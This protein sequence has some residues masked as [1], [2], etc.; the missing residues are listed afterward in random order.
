MRETWRWFGSADQVALDD[1]AQAGA[2]GIVTALHHIAPGD[3]WSPEEI[4]G[5]QAEIR[6]RTAHLPQPMEWDVVE[7]LPVSEDIKRQTGNWRDHVEAY[8]SS[9][10][11][12]AQAGLE[13]ICYNFMPLL[14]WTRTDL[15]YQVSNRA[16]C[17][18]FDL[19]DFAMFDLFLLK[20][21][22]AASDFPEE[23][24]EAARR[25]FSETDDT[26]KAALVSNVICGLPGG[27]DQL[28]LDDI[29]AH[30]AAYEPYDHAAL[31]AHQAA[32]LES[33]VPHAQSLGL[34]LCC[35]PDDPP[36]SLL[37][38]PRI[39]STEAD[40]TRLVTSVDLPANGITLCSGSLGARADNDLPGIMRRLGA[41]VHFLHLRNVAR[42]HDAV[43]GSF[44]ESEHLGGD[45]DMPALI[46][47]VLA[48][49]ESRRQGDRDDSSIPFRPDHG[50]DILDDLS[51]RAQPGYPAIGR[52]K[53]LAELR[54]VIAGL[55]YAARKE[56]AE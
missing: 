51:R 21:Q 30:L 39:M 29:R 14:D 42:E 11:N 24:A 38:L 7:S 46:S 1:V 35:H 16:T 28:T 41:H 10:T 22:G 31:C 52:L 45:V 47:A 55:E 50:Q 12:L 20:R 49:E 23:V 15:A 13:T 43:F 32:F 26:F 9:L 34:R 18:R 33:V 53:G 8:K 19:V 17:M 36:Y 27:N 25:R 2:R 6:N 4:A 56:A 44:H 48:E 37:G 40:Y 54:G 5:R 3:V